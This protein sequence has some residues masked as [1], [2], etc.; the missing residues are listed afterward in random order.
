MNHQCHNSHQELSFE[1]SRDVTQMG[2]AK[3]L[4]FL[5]ILY[6]ECYLWM[7]IDCL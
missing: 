5:V 3:V 6:N 7:G 2:K 1:Q 4:H